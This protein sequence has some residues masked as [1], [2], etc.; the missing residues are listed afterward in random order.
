MSVALD[1][2]LLKT[3][4]PKVKYGFTKQLLA[5]GAKDPEALRSHFDEIA[6]M[7]FNENNVIKWTGI[8][9]IG[10]Y[11]AIDDENRTD[12]YILHLLKF[13]HGGTLI[14][15]NHAIFALGLIAL[16]KPVHRNKILKQLISIRKDEFE[17]E[18]CKNIAIGKVID[19]L[20]PFK[21]EVR[22][23]KSL[24]DFVQ[25]ASANSRKATANK[26][27]KLVKAMSAKSI[28]GKTKNVGFEVGVRKIYPVDQ[29]EVWNY[30]SSD[31]G[32]TFWLGELVK[33]RLIENNNYKTV[34]G[35]EGT[36]RILR[37]YSHIRLTWK[38][39]DW[40]NH[41]TLQM[42]VIA[43]KKKTTVSFHQEKLADV[44]QRT[45][46]KKHWSTIL[47]KLAKE[48]K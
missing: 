45:E 39:A 26:A 18:E 28:T 25:A 3:R 4:D 47:D 40:K 22:K 11:A 31:E 2:E 6:G 13:L 35:V 1:F 36:V 33:G 14:S 21:D 29:T 5:I 43:G 46:M 17:T 15:A 7:L 10:Y 9:L 30:L 27:A 24:M 12:R 16:H 23:L 38:K 48:I 32:I 34:D 44:R 41:S 19:T 8:D 42:R 20:V 37:P